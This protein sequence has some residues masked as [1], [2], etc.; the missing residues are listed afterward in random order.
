MTLADPLPADETKTT[1][2]L[3]PPHPP[4][5]A[6]KPKHIIRKRRQAKVKNHKRS[7]TIKKA[8]HGIT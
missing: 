7:P 4:R 6:V 3:G 5:I 2:S 1:A 8:L